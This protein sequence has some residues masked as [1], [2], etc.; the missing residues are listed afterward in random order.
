MALPL[1]RGTFEQ[2]V[3]IYILGRQRQRAAE[4]KGSGG[5]RYVQIFEIYEI[6]SNAFMFFSA[7]HAEKR[8]KTPTLMFCNCY[9]FSQLFC[10]KFSTSIQKN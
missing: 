4:K 8:S 2:V 3:S 5:G 10:G 9:Y 7:R 1:Q 6:F